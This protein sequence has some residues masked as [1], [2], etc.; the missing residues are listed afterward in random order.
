MKVCLKCNKLL[1]ESQFYKHGNPKY[2]SGRN[3]C[4]S[5]AIIRGKYTSSCVVI[6][7]ANQISHYIPEM[8][9]LYGRF[10][11][12]LI[13]YQE[14]LQFPFYNL[15]FH[16]KLINANVLKTINP[17][18]RLNK[19][20]FKFTTSFIDYIENNPKCTKSLQKSKQLNIKTP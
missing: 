18:D 2:A 14:L 6:L 5:C 3:V 19:R 8:K 20:I 12:N 17:K 16:H 1:D 7:N 11:H 4:K 9:Q 15:K 10:K 13:A